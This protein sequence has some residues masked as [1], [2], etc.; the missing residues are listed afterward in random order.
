[1]RSMTNDDRL[2]ETLNAI[3]GA[4]TRIADRLDKQDVDFA[5][6]REHTREIARGVSSIAKNGIN[7]FEQNTVN[8]SGFIG[9]AD[10]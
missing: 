6:S 10:S 8:V 9:D 1:M 5:I 3:N 7:T 2:I 4:L